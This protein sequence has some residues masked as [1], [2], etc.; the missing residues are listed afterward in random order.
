MIE[1]SNLK[2]TRDVHILCDLDLRNIKKMSFD[3]FGK[4]AP[5]LGKQLWIL[6]TSF[7]ENLFYMKMYLKLHPI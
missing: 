1:I 2:I 3:L 4:M 7:N 5:C 6:H